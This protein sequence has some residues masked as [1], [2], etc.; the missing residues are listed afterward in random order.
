MKLKSEI[1]HS[2]GDLFRVLNTLIML[3]FYTQ[4]VLCRLPPSGKSAELSISHTLLTPPSQGSAV[5]GQLCRQSNV[6]EVLIPFKGTKPS[7]HAL[8]LRGHSSHNSAM[9]AAVRY[10]FLI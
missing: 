4:E 6:T 10:K 8:R 3:L 1:P 2:H 5:P 7:N 9:D